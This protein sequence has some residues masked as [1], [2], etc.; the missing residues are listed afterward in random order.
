MRSF[1]LRRTQ[2]LL[3]HESVNI[4][5]PKALWVD[6]DFHRLKKG[7]IFRLFNT[8]N[9]RERPDFMNENGAHQVCV[10]LSGAKILK[11]YE[12]E[13]YYVQSLPLRGI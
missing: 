9:G 10:A 13:N 12:T 6:V 5:S 3:V 2:K 8:A 7:D 1:C 11:G 4:D